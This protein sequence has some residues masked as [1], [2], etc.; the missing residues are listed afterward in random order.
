MQLGD[1]MAGR[2]GR[3]G[4][5]KAP[6]KV[7]RFEFLN[8]FK[9]HDE[10]EPTETVAND[11]GSIYT[12][13]LRNP[14]KQPEFSFLQVAFE[15]YLEENFAFSL[16]L[17]QKYRGSTNYA[18]V[19]G[20]DYITYHD[21][22]QRLNTSV[23]IVER[24]DE[25]GLLA[26]NPQ[27]RKKSP[28]QWFKLVSREAVSALK[29]RWRYG[30]PLYEAARL[31]GVSQEITRGMMAA[32]LI[33][34]VTGP[35]LD[36]YKVWKIGSQSLAY[37]FKRL[38]RGGVRYRYHQP[39]KLISLAIAAETVAQ[40]GLDTV[41]LIERILAGELRGYW[42]PEDKHLGQL[43]VSVEDLEALQR[44]HQGDKSRPIGEQM[45]VEVATIPTELDSQVAA[46]RLTA[47]QLARQLGIDQSQLWPWTRRGIVTLVPEP[48]LAESQT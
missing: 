40:D 7:Y 22:A 20:S 13:W 4:R 32:G 27:S 2:A 9:L 11:L 38:E 18:E 1:W 5:R 26:S 29:Q 44:A 45:D 8:A 14:W 3:S 43:R 36:G 21:A 19:I 24:S 23:V 47:P 39:V 30:I 25:L 16:A 34:A 33:K 48:E 17:Q 6:G 41:F 12:T 42:P 46:A 15:Q 37:F 10:A 28:P 31:L 35:E